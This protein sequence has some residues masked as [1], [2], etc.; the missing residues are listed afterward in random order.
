M[1]YRLFYLSTYDYLKMLCMCVEFYVLN[2]LSIYVNL[3]LVTSSV[4]EKKDVDRQTLLRYG[5]LK[6]PHVGH[7]YENRT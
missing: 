5:T 7:Q 4:H 6:M 2:V 3:N 1:D